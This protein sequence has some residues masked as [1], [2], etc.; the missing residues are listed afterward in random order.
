MTHGL[1]TQD[2]EMLRH[3]EALG[4]ATTTRRL[5]HLASV[6][7]LLAR[8]TVARLALAG[9]VHCSGSGGPSGRIVRLVN[10]SDREE[11][12]TRDVAA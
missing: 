10:A 11:R 1:S 7:D 8:K 2:R 12:A 9:L 3:L 6:P 4:T 5:A